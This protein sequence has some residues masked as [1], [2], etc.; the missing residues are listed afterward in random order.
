MLLDGRGVQLEDGSG[1]GSGCGG[2][3]AAVG[4]AGTSGAGGAAGAGGSPLGGGRATL[5]GGAGAGEGLGDAQ[6]LAA[7][8]SIL[9]FTMN[10]SNPLPVVSNGGPPLHPLGAGATGLSGRPKKGTGS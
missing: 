1:R 6:G 2:D 5:G 3:G 7:P 4:G 8:H 10:G 9:C